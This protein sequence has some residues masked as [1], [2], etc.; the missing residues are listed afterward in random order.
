MFLCALY[1]HP[2]LSL[3]AI[4]FRFF[5]FLS[6]SFKKSNFGIPIY[7]FKQVSLDKRY[8]T[9]RRKRVNL[10]VTVTI[11]TLF[12]GFIWCVVNHLLFTPNILYT[13]FPNWC[14]GTTI[15]PIAY[16]NCSPTKSNL[17]QDFL[18]Y[19]RALIFLSKCP[20]KYTIIGC[21][22]LFWV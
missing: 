16:I 21:M 7:Y 10:Y 15:A 2:S 3:M 4:F 11:A 13:S 20:P 6:K 19:L 5:K 12:Q 1:E 8:G 17:G 14:S 9:C 22:T 18:H